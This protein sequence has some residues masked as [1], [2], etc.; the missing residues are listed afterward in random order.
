MR[1]GVRTEFTVMAKVQPGHEQAIRETI[2]SSFAD[3]RRD[4]ALRELGTLH[5]ARHVLFDKDTRYLFASSFDG[6]WDK[7]IEDFAGSFS[8]VV[9]DRIL[10]HCEDY[11]GLHSP[12]LKDWIVDHQVDA[13]AFAVAYPEATVRQVWRALGLQRAFE[14][15]LDDP[16]AS[17]ALSVPTL[18]PLR[19]LAAA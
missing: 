9:L 10:N 8:G 14:H 17:E 12:G 11:P 2:Q 16:E 1:S 7:Y 13:V 4:Q 18:E 3:P 15:V 5:E 6:D 19:D